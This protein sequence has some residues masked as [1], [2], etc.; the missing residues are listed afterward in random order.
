MQKINFQNYPN[1]STPINSTNLNQLQTN[2]E[3]EIGDL[4]NL[5]TDVKTS[6]VNAINSLYFKAGDEFELD[7]FMPCPGFLTS[8]NK[9]LVFS[10]VVPKSMKN[11][12]SISISG[13]LYIDIRKP[14]G[15]YI[16]GNVNFNT[17]TY[18]INIIK[19]TDNVL[20]LSIISPTNFDSV[21]NQP[22]C[23]D[24]HSGITFVFS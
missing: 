20:R 16:A 3:N 17:S 23:G 21:N 5:D 7:T 24:I 10:I 11:V 4:S 1:T 15:G 22:L 12:N 14:A 9:E 6:V 19:I 2:I 8:G 18:T 13:D